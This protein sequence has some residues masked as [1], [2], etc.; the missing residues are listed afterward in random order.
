MH[1]LDPTTHTVEMTQLADLNERLAAQANGAVVTAADL[2]LEGARP[3]APAPPLAGSAA[4]LRVCWDGA[5]EFPYIHGDFGSARL[6]VLVD[7]HTAALRELSHLLHAR[8]V[9]GVGNADATAPL[10]RR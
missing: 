2:G 10:G 5:P 6:P 4:L 7:L 1:R 9:W 3:R 8:H